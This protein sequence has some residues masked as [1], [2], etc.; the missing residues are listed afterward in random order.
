V[1]SSPRTPPSEKNSLPGE[2]YVTVGITAGGHWV[3]HPAVYKKWA[4]DAHTTGTGSLSFPSQSHVT[5]DGQSVSQSWCRAP[6][7]THDQMFS[8]IC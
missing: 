6:S 5:A 4:T 7:G 2:N 8:P 1:N 3:T